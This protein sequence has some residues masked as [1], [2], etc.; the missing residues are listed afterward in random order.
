[1]TVQKLTLILLSLFGHSSFTLAQKNIDTQS[2]MWNRF[3]LKINANDN[4]QVLQEL[5]ER[6]YWFPWRQ[7][8]FVSRTQVV[9]SLGKGWTTSLGFTYFLQSLP[10]DQ[11]TSVTESLSELR[12]QIEFGSRQKVLNWFS[13]NHR[14]R[15]ELR[16]FEQSDGAIEFG[17]ARMRYQLEFQFSPVKGLTLKVFDEI[18]FNIGSKIVLNVFDQNRVGASVQYQFMNALGLELGYFNWFQQ[19]ASGVDFFNR[20]IVR[21]TILYTIN[22]PSTE[23]Q[24]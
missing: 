21:C 10:H 12:P 5:E 13:I 19:R 14:Y 9:R 20:H 3:F 17:N 2:L 6:S 1:M 22:L 18:H 8:Q 11:E 7:H 15:G 16:F 23:K 24:T 4:Y